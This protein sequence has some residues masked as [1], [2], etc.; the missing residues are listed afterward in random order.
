MA[1]LSQQRMIDL[2]VSGIGGSD[3]GGSSCGCESIALFK[4]AF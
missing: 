2:A 1:V 4:P 3:G